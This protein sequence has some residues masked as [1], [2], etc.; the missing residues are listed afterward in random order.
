[1]ARHICIMK[2]AAAKHKLCGSDFF[3]FAMRSDVNG[4]CPMDMIKVRY[5]A[6]WL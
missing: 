4:I 1:M 6:A 3:I 2:V 5:C